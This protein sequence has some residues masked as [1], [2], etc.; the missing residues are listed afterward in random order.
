MIQDA[1]YTNDPNIIKNILEQGTL[2]YNSQ[3]IY[4]AIIIYTGTEKITVQPS[5]STIYI[6]GNYTII[7]QNNTTIEFDKANSSILYTNSTT[8]TIDDEPARTIQIVN[9]NVIIKNNTRIQVQP[10]TS[11]VFN[12]CY[13]KI[14]AS[15]FSLSYIGLTFLYSI[16]EYQITSNVSTQ[17]PTTYPHSI[18]ESTFINSLILANNTYRSSSTSYFGLTIRSSA[19]IY[20]VMLLNNTLIK[21]S[22]ITNCLFPESSNDIIIRSDNSLIVVN[23]IM[24][25][26]IINMYYDTI[27]QYGHISVYNQT[28]GNIAYQDKSLLTHKF[29]QSVVVKNEDNT[30]TYKVSEGLENK[31][32]NN[33]TEKEGNIIYYNVN[34]NVFITET[35]RASAVYA[36]GCP[37][38][39]HMGICNVISVDMPDEVHVLENIQYGIGNIYTGRLKLPAEY[40]VLKI[41]GRYGP[42][43]IGKFDVEPY[44]KQIYITHKKE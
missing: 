3:Q 18:S 17:P 2:Y 22:Y 16:I 1:I 8:I 12:S 44:S 31:M 21:D 7:S 42:D 6:R 35:L 37:V 4:K 19:M 13:I 30:V 38:P 14:Q 32:N 25:K 26:N 20:C 23:S 5:S 41:F 24:N 11:L 10:Q 28:V 39:S 43:K 15:N 27:Y 36:R 29:T 34:P 33:L 40:E 9:F